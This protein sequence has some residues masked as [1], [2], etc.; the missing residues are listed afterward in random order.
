MKRFLIAL[1]AILVLL[2]ISGCIEM[3]HCHYWTTTP[4]IGSDADY[5]KGTAL[6]KINSVPGLIGGLGIEAIKDAV[7]SAN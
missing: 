1:A 5:I 4:P 6:C 3:N 7:G 2:L